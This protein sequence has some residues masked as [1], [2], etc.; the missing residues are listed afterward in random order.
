MPVFN[1][2]LPSIALQPSQ[3][4]LDERKINRSILLDVA[5]DREQLLMSDIP[6]EEIRHHLKLRIASPEG[7]W[8]YRAQKL[9]EVKLRNA[10]TRFS[11]FDL[12]GLAATSA[13]ANANAAAPKPAQPTQIPTRRRVLS[14]SATPTHPIQLTQSIERRFSFFDNSNQSTANTTTTTTTSSDTWYDLSL[15]TPGTLVSPRPLGPT[16]ILI[17]YSTTPFNSV[18]HSLVA[19]KK[20]TL[21]RK[22]N[23]NMTFPEII[24]IPINDLLFLLSETA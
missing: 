18:T 14:S 20:P 22:N 13:N 6:I 17:I 4:G 11:A 2:T 8:L 24:E 7:H 21:R 3:T 1:P 12:A 9:R 15:S 23:F 16:H 10:T 5:P 19:R